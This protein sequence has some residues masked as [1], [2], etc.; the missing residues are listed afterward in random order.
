MCDGIKT[1]KHNLRTTLRRA[2]H[3]HKN[4]AHE[5]NTSSKT[6]QTVATAI[7]SRFACLLLFQTPK[8]QK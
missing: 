3:G 1:L 4:L 5:Q 2:C 8:N 6:T 7:G